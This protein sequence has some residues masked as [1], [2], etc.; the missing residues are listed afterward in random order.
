[1]PAAAARAAR[2]VAAAIDAAQDCGQVSGG[3][4]S[5][6]GRPCL[7]SIVVAGAACVAGCAGAVVACSLLLL[8]LL[9]LAVAAA[10]AA[11]S[12]SAPTASASPATA[13]VLLLIV[14]AAPAAAPSL[15]HV[16][17]WPAG[18][19]LHGQA[20]AA[21]R[22]GRAGAVGGSRAECLQLQPAAVR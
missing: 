7:I 20:A 21:A 5:G 10:V 17:S 14:P 18:T 16:G 19:A 11:T 15:A 4:R 6:R 1:M 8:L 13:A 9:L 3:A 22:R 2:L 12:S